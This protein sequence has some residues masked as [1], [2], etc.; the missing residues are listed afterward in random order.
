MSK[1]NLIVKATALMAALTLSTSCFVGGT[2][3]KYVSSGTGS[4]TARV[5]K[6]GVTVTASADTF[7][8]EYLTNDPDVNAEGV[9]TKSV[10]STDDVVAPGTSGN[11]AK[12]NLEGTPEVAVK[13]TYSADLDL[14]DKWAVDESYYCPIKIN[15]CGKELKGLDYTNA[16]S[17]EAAVESLIAGYSQ[18]YDAEN[19][20]ST[21]TDNLSIYW[22]W[23]F[24]GGTGTKQYQSDAKD[25][26]LGDAATAATIG[27]S[28]TATVTQID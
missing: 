7:V 13:V 21:V 4:D 11:M 28:V 14:G 25:T 6:W 27:L 10:V 5:A 2:F 19:D 15:V 22:E 20:L 8:K 16:G 1:K 9:I 24:E 3:A 26:K 17:F 23:P 18:I 12:I